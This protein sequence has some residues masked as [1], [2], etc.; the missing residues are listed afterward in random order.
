MTQGV[1]LGKSVRFLE[2][3]LTKKVRNMEI[4][5]LGIDGRPGSI[6]RPLGFT[7][8]L[9]EIGSCYTALVASGK[10]LKIRI[11]RLNEAI[12]N[13]VFHTPAAIGHLCLDAQRLAL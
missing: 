2:H 10:R 13:V 8:A 1:S 7:A 3:Q 6:M 4:Y 11:P 12:R 5:P 9:I